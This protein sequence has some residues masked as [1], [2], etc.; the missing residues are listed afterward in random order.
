MSLLSNQNIRASS[1]VPP[2]LMSTPN[3]IIKSTNF[4]L[5]SISE[6]ITMLSGA[7]LLFL[8]LKL[9]I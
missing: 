2:S 4:K 3:Y 9:K 8:T 7:F 6:Q 1:S 5:F